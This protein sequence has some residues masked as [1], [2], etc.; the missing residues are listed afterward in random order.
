M[1]TVLAA[2]TTV[3]LVFGLS[4]CTPKPDVADEVAQEFLSAMAARSTEQAGDL[5]DN[6][7]E[8]HDQLDQT[9][10][11]MQ[12]EGLS[13]VLQRVN[14]DGN[15]ATATYRMDWSLPG[16][17]HFGYDSTM[18]LTKSGDRW[19]VRWQPSV[20]HPDLGARQHMELRKVAAKTANVVGSDGAVLLEPGTI[21]R[22]VLNTDTAGN[23]GGAITRIARELDVL[24]A[25]DPAVPNIDA[26]ALARE[27]ADVDG[28][29][30]VVTLGEIPGKKLQRA[31]DGMSGLRF[32]TEAAMVRP[33]PG[34]APDIMSR[35]SSLVEDD[36]KG[37]DGWKVVSVNTEGAELTT[38][39][40]TDAQPAPSVHISL[41]RQI[42]QAAQSAVDTRKGAEAMMVVM[43]PSTGEILAVAQ[44]KEAD[45]K[46]NLALTGQ[47][48]P[49]STFKMVTAYAGL[50]EED[51][52][53]DSMVGC[54]G[55]QDIGGRIVTNYNGF[56]L[57]TTPLQNA[58]AKSCNTTFADI[59][60]KLEPGHLQEIAKQFGLG[61]DYQIEGLDTIT[62]S[63]PHGE[64]MLDRT[65]SGYGQGLNLVSPF[66]MAL[67]ASAAASGSLPTPV[68]IP[69]EGH[70]TSAKGTV[71]ESLKP[72]KIEELRQMMRAVVTNGSGAGIAGAGEVYGKTGEAEINGGSHSWFAGYRD[73]IAFATLVVLGGGSE[74]AVGVTNSFFSNLDEYSGAHD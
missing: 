55:T 16:D 28:D 7:Q 63:V 33:D 18:K 2:T 38:L 1:R 52:T 43:R 53:P 30:S 58:F 68:L 21:T 59:S 17:R 46:G 19:N 24:R 49:G 34:F 9:W 60:T 70:E 66:G 14:T 8:A 12:A 10:E 54:P 13:A 44:T 41:S 48:P 72:E 56:S 42:Q 22:V 67:V 50:T 36:L 3:G 51:L 4:A 40:E 6:P 57:G 65:E 5:T 32:N 73:D 37:K 25:E 64:T 26:D 62:G 20:V 39:N 45:K 29:F 61:V 31:L 23:V 15:I 71:Q 35:V 27:A 74:N 11:S 69:G 47:F